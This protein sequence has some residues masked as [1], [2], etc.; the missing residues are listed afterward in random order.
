MKID[1]LLETLRDL[2]GSQNLDVDC[3]KFGPQVLEKQINCTQ[4]RTPPSKIISQGEER[5]EL[6]ESDTTCPDVRPRVTL[7]RTGNGNRKRREWRSICRNRLSRHIGESLGIQVKPSEVRL[8]AGDEYAP[9]AW[10][11]DDPSIKPLFDK[12]ISK[13]S[14][15]AYI[16]LYQYVG[17]SFRAIHPQDLMKAVEPSNNSTCQD[18]CPG[19]SVVEHQCRALEPAAAQQLQD[20]ETDSTKL[21]ERLEQAKTRALSR[22]WADTDFQTEM[23]LSIIR[24]AQTIIRTHQRLLAV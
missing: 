16:A 15:G 18:S 14:V 7:S 24:D 21:L 3:K 13:H 2:D 6:V 12:Q 11:I 20:L 4:I 1:A 22:T 8:K 19:Q 10:Q 9:Y 23:L 17:R 5:G